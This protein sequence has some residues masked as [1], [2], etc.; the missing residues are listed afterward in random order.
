VSV[1]IFTASLWYRS[2]L[3]F[4]LNLWV[5]IV[6]LDLIPL[7]VVT[8]RVLLARYKGI[9]QFLASLSAVIPLNFVEVWIVDT[10]QYS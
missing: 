10:Q 8:I 5:I 9:F 2:I 7:W 4:V 6:G 1:N 3:S